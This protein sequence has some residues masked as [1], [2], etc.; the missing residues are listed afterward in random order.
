MVGGKVGRGAVKKRRMINERGRDKGDGRKIMRFSRERDEFL[1][2][3]WKV[4][5]EEGR[6]ELRKGN[7]MMNG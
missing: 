5:N 1:G 7:R 3:R 6:K 4:S 2:W